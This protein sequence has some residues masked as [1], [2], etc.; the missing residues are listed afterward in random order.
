M[1]EDEFLSAR[2]CGPKITAKIL[3]LQA[4]Y[5]KDIRQKKPREAIGGVL[6]NNWRWLNKLI[7]VA[8]VANDVVDAACRDVQN[9]YYVR[10]TTKRFNMLKRSLEALGRLG[11]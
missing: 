9:R 10:I 11:D 5:G 7:A 3:Q 8:L 6:Q 2:N 1:D 4:E